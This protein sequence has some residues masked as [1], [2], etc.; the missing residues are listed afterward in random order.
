[1]PNAELCRAV[2]P[3]TGLPEWSRP[4]ARHSRRRSEGVQEREEF[5]IGSEPIGFFALVW[6]EFRE[7]RLLQSEMGV[8]ID[9]GGATDSWLSHKAITEHSTPAWRSS[10]AALC[11][12]MWGETRFCFKDGIRSAATATCWPIRCWT[13]STLRR[14]PCMLGKRGKWCIH[15]DV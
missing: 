9:L 3:W 5:V 13:A 10:M 12:R 1:M 4:I 7:R 2:T 6:A 11:R 8:Q 14:F 15:Q